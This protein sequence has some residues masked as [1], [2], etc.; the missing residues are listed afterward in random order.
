MDLL[1]VILE[2]DLLMTPD[3]LFAVA[4]FFSVSRVVLISE[5]TIFPRCFSCIAVLR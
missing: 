5:D 3:I 4:V 2:A 1:G